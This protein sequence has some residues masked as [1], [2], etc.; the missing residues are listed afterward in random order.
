VQPE[1]CA[2]GR[3]TGSPL[4]IKEWSAVSQSRRTVIAGLVLAL[5]TQFYPVFAVAS[6]PVAWQ[7]WTA[8]QP[9]STTTVDHELWQTLLDKHV[10]THADGINRV[11]YGNFDDDSTGLL[12]RYLT[13]LSQLNPTE[14][15]RSEQ[16]AYWINL[17][18]AQ[19]VQVVLDHPGKKS[20]R[21]MG[22]LFAFGPWDEAYLRI[23]DQK[24]TL[25]DIEH[26][27]LRP[28]WQ[29]HRLHFVLNCASIGCPNLSQQAYT[30]DRVETQL[31]QAEATFLQHPRA[32]SLLA[33]GALKLSSLFD[34]YQ[35]DFADNE[36]AL[37]LYLA[38]HRADL[39]A[40]LAAQERPYK[41]AIDYDYDWNLN[42]S[43]Q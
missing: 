42:K 12:Q 17:Y 7:H 25:N 11:D 31:S 22:P 28:I 20:I 34:W 1:V 10:T 36:E 8:H 6:T 37:L 21:A 4:I 26:R 24:V 5:I 32:V 19:T 9:A 13:Y 41:F 15:N 3:L 23:E 38:G 33:D 18:N 30:A 2:D 35:A 40:R 16:L 43:S 27:I 14:L 39:A 29:D